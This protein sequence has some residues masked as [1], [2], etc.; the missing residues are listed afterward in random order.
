MSKTLPVIKSLETIRG[1]TVKIAFN[2]GVTR[3]LDLRPLLRGPVFRSIVNEG[4]FS[5]VLIADDNLAVKW[6]NGAGIPSEV[7][8]YDNF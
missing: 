7:L 4:T 8:R 6:P 2:D 1:M 5:K 3:I